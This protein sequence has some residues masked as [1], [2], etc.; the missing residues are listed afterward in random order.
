MDPPPRVRIAILETD[1]R[2]AKESRDLGEFILMKFLGSRLLFEISPIKITP[3]PN[4]ILFRRWSECLYQRTLE[5]HVLD[6]CSV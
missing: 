1:C 4:K 6:I 5:S 2:C 3:S